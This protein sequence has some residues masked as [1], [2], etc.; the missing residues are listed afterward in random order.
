MPLLAN[1][2]EEIVTPVA[3]NI[4]SYAKF[5]LERLEASVIGPRA[6]VGEQPKQKRHS[7]CVCYPILICID[8]LYFFGLEIGPKA[9]SVRQSLLRLIG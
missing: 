8:V 6:S 9:I 5:N 4:T 7:E 1:L 2:D 3:S